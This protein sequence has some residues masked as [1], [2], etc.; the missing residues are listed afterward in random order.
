[1]KKTLAL[2]LAL[3]L[4]FAL[5]ACGQKAQTAEPP[6][7]APT[8]TLLQGG[9][10]VEAFV[11]VSDYNISLYAKDSQELLA[12]LPYPK[13]LPGAKDASLKG[14]LADYDGDGYSEINI[15]LT[16]S[17]GETAN[18]LWWY[19]DGEYYYN[20]EFSYMPGEGSAKGD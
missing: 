18:L 11:V 13:T 5:T 9:E 4:T 10:K 3:I 20:Q 1:M 14:D 8:V 6:L 7:S 15:K 12:L 19:A 2:T 16:F 17:D